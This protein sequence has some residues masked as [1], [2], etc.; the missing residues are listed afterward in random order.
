MSSKR[1]NFRKWWFIPRKPSEDEEHRHVSFLEL[2]Y[3]L[4]YVIIIAE[5]A[6]A[7]AIDISL[8]NIGK[9]VFLFVIIWWAWL[10]GSLYHELHGR[11]DLRTRFFTFLQMFAVVGMAI[12]AHSAIGEGAMGFSLSYAAFLLIVTYLWWGTGRHDPVH[13]LLS[14][15]YSLVFAIVTIIFIASA[16]IPHPWYLI[17]WGVGLFLSLLLPFVLMFLSRNNPEMQEEMTRSSFRKPSGVERFGLFTI[18]VLGEVIVGVISG[19]DAHHLTWLIGGATV[20]G[21]LIAISLWWI[22]FSFVAR[23]MPRLEL[24]RNFGWGYLHLPLT[25]SIA[26]IGP[27]ITN[28]IVHNEEILSTE[29]RWLFVGATAVV[30]LSIAI[31]TSTLQIPDYRKQLFL[32]GRI[33]HIV[34]AILLLILGIFEM[35]SVLFMGIIALLLVTPIFWGIKAWIAILTKQESK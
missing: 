31:M 23:R 5:I 4:V 16:F 9:F 11:D 29:V 30:L 8:I 2:F 19:I 20:I 35:N 24:I 25:I 18:I 32:R 21:V 22:Y 27:A 7:L 3:D 15:P 12:F 26:A 13:R 10:N 33:I 17:T 1:E 14:T 6:H 34:T 28:V